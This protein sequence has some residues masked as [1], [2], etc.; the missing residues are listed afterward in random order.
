[1]C[2]CEG[3]GR[4]VL[5]LCQPTGERGGGGGGVGVCVYVGGLGEMFWSCVS[6]RERERG[7]RARL[8]EGKVGVCV[9][10]GEGGGGQ[11]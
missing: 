10:V 3:I 11:D 8:T 4:N 7:G 6:Q 9:Y 5:V 2:V 1:M